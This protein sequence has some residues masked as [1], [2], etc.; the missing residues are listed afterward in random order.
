MRTLSTLL[1]FAAVLCFGLSHADAQK[2]PLTARPTVRRTVAPTAPGDPL[3]KAHRATTGKAIAAP[4]RSHASTGAQRLREHTRMHQ[5]AAHGSE[6]RGGNP[7]NDACA[8]AT[9]LT[10]NATGGCPGGAMSGDN[11]AATSDNGTPACD[12]SDVGFQDV[13][14]SFNSGANT[15]IVIDLTMGTIVDIGIELL[16]GGCAGTSVFCNF[17]SLSY[18]VSVNTNTNYRLRV[19]S[20]NDFGA[21]GTFDICLSAAGDPPPN[22]LCEDADIQSLNV[23]GSVTVNGDNTGATDTEGNGIPTAWEAFT[24]NTCADVTISYCGTDPAFGNGFLNLRIGCPEVDYFLYTDFDTTSCADG[25]LTIYYT[26]VPA[27]TYYYAVLTETG[28]VGPYT[29]GFSAVACG[30]GGTPPNDQCFNVVPS[31]LAA[32]SSVFFDGTTENATNTNDGAGV[33]A[34]GDTVTV[35]HA[36]T[37]TEC[38]DIAVAYCGTPVLPASYWAVLFEGCPADDAGFLF[39]GGNFDDCGDDNAT[40]FFFGLPAGTWYLPVRGEPATW[41]TYSIEVSATACATAGPYCDAGAALSGFETIGNVQ[42]AGIDNTS[43][44]GPG[45]QNFTQETGVV[46]LGQSYPIDI[47]VDGGFDTDEAL[48]WIDFDQSETFE[49]GEQVFTSV[50]GVGPYSGNIAIPGGAATGSTRMRIRLH[51]THDGTDYPNTPNYTPCDT[52][53]YGQV[54]D[55]AIMVT[56]GGPGPEND[57]CGDVTAENLTVGGSLVFTGDNTGA[58]ITGDFEP[59]SDLE[60]LGFATVWHAF[61]TTECSNI[62]VSYCATEPAFVDFWSFLSTACPTGD[63][64]VLNSSVNFTDCAN[65]DITIFYNNLPAGTWYLPVMNDPAPGTFSVGPYSIDVSAAACI[66]GPPNDE[67]AGAIMLDVNLTCEPTQGDVSNA[68]QSMPAI[69]CNDFEGMANDDVWYSFV[70]TG[71]NQTITVDGTDTLDAVI[72]LFEGTCVDLTSLACA[73]STL[74]GDV[75]EIEANDLVEGT[76]YFVRVYDFYN[77]YPIEPTFDICVTGDVGT[78][79]AETENHG[80]MLHP[81]P[82]EGQVTMDLG[83]ISGKVLVEILDVAGRSVQVEQ[84]TVS[85]GGSIVIGLSG[86]VSAGLYTVRLTSAG[87][88]SEQRLLVK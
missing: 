44:G 19:F 60:G 35:W 22:D 78:A 70:A 43:I 45:Y 31:S 47:V 81:N 55:Y 28:S 57:N 58:T 18:T 33:N 9:A 30:S 59:G 69:V 75:E 39:S 24:I 52:S 23:P 1:S 5:E 61:T 77:G 46:V 2:A 49:A 72:E 85:N 34:G 42:F 82:A 68:T 38:T 62:T 27:G 32:G 7:V 29:L 37:T 3:A 20:N 40:I 26:D 65:Q 88:R 83:G 66:A 63:D 15:Q 79:V 41:G 48:V 13:W 21:G 73:D 56:D 51:D 71:P 10:V 53:T 86:N 16:Q 87:Q 36:F 8:G 4:Q 64:V 6:L 76:T 11:G 67:C 54:E 74:G 84:R 17:N 50:I 12:A 14:Y 25:N 80:F